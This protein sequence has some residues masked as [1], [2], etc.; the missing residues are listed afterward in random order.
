MSIFIQV[1]ALGALGLVLG[2]AL[3]YVGRIFAVKENENLIAIREALPGVN[4]GACGQPGCDGFA[5][6]LIEG[7][8]KTNECPVGGP[9]LSSRLSEILGVQEAEAD[10]QTAYV[11]CYGT[12]NASK[13]HYAYNGIDNCNAAFLMPGSGPKACTFSCLGHGSCAVVCPFDAIDIIDAIAVINPDK[14]VACGL[15]IPACP[16]ALITMV[17][18]RAKIRVGC[19][20][21][22]RGPLVRANCSAGC[23]ACKICER[24]CPHDAINVVDNLAVVHYD[25][26]VMCGICAEKCP[27]GV[28]GPRVENAG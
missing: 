21:T 3:G 24:H 25:K 9:D 13:I 5:T 10:K 18:V 22:D 6:A 28:V 27:T 2:G 4:C 11:H 17:P 20:S 12:N 23:I 16:K 14:C 19:H 8:A 7:K 26:C 1:A 15:C